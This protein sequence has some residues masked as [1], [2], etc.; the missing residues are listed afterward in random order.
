MLIDGNSSGILQLC[1]VRRI[2]T[3]HR[4]CLVRFKGQ[5]SAT[6]VGI[7]GALGKSSP[8]QVH[9]SFV[10]LVSRL[11]N[12][13]AVSLADSR[14]SLARCDAGYSSIDEIRWLGSE[15]QFR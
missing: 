9:R 14:W 1:L 2:A 8:F 7:D 5:P 15:G 10:M 12:H 6:M 11:I 13:P 4:S 3:V